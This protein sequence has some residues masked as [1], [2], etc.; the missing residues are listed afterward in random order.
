MSDS[1]PRIKIIANGPLRVTGTDL[2]RVGIERNQWNRPSA[3]GDDR[4]VEHG[5][6]YSLCRCGASS[7][8][9]FCDGTHRNVD[10]DPAE[11]AD[12]APTATRRREWAGDGIAMT[13]D[14]SLC[15]HAGFCVREYG[16]AWDLVGTASGEEET[17][18]V[19]DM[20]HACPSSRLQFHEPAGSEPVEPEVSPRAA[21]IDDG[22]VFVEGG[23]PLEGADG[24]AYETLNRM[25]L[26][27]CGASANKPYC[28]GTHS[29]NDFKDPA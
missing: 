6:A 18:R 28:D 22:P 29:R 12:R 21:V 16:K 17:S 11:T 19:R 13:D 7:N 26:C 2:C 3:Y 24:E 15:W 20:I 8:K 23:V 4:P 10:W 27:R 1:G 5:E 9:P 14:K 25:S